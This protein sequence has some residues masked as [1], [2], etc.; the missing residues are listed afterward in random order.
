[1]FGNTK[2]LACPDSW[3]KLSE[4]YGETTFNGSKFN[5][6]SVSIRSNTVQYAFGESAP[7]L[8]Y[9]HPMI[10]Y[11]FLRVNE[12]DLNRL[13]FKNEASGTTGYLVITPE[14]AF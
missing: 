6:V 14:I 1:M 7:Q 11:D 10:P 3:T 4:I 8:Y 9:G 13:W 5:G 12:D 2:Y